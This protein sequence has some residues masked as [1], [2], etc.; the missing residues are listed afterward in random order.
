[1]SSVQLCCTLHPAAKE[2]AVELVG[3]SSSWSV[4]STRREMNDS[5]VKRE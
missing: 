5:F 4:A 2:E 3:Y 1:V